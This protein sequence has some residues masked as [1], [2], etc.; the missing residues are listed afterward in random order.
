MKSVLIIE[1]T[2]LFR[3]YLRTKLE[4]NDIEVIAA[5]NGLDGIAKLRSNDPDLVIIDYNLRRQGCMEVLKQ[6]KASPSLARIPVI[7]TARELDQ[8]KILELIQY[9]I[10]KVFTK[11]VKIDAL[12]ST[13]Q[14]IL[15]VSFNV[16]TNPGIVEVHANDDIIFIEIT[17]GLNRD[18]LDLLRFKI[19]ELVELYQIKIPKLIVMISGFELSAADN[20]NLTI[21]LYNILKSSKASQR[22]IRILTRDNFLKNFIKTQKEFSDIEV[23]SS[24]QYALDGFLQDLET[25]EDKEVLIG[26]RVLSRA[27]TE[28]ESMQLRFDGETHFG[29]DDVKESLQGLSIAAVDDDEIIRELI[30]AT[31]KGFDLELSFFPDGAEFISSLGSKRYDLVLLDIIM[32]RA[33][34]FSVLR[35]MREQNISIPVIILSSVNQ[36]ETVIRAFQMGIKSYLAKPLKPADI[37]KKT[38]E[39]LRVNY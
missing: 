35:E 1:E 29:L 10:K 23:V 36:Q 33:D 3:E 7:I 24:L 4:S 9:N 30:K 34:G 37:F 12:F 18:K 16:D 15:G 14:E 5:I 27:H 17:E 39:I 26:D 2:S 6:K 8:N 28:G 38:L 20:P 13:V 31:F 32:P 22:N 11:P 21:L 25:A 19:I